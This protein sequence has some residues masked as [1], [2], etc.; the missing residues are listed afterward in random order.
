MCPMGLLSGLN[1]Y[2]T[3]KMTTG[4]CPQGV[5][6]VITGR[7]LTHEPADTRE[8][9]YWRAL[10]FVH[11]RSSILKEAHFKVWGKV[12]RVPTPGQR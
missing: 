3:R 5:L 9:A 7:R 11:K 4:S 2:A 1:Y 8:Y 6:S 12:G 10:R